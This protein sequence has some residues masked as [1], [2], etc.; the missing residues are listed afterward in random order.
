MNESAIDRRPLASRRL[1]PSRWA[2][3][4]LARSGVTPNQISLAGMFF[5]LASGV[6]LLA[7]SLA[8]APWFRV[9]FVA[10]AVLVQLRLLCNMLDGM[11]A[12]EQGSSS[13]VGELFNEIPDRVSDSATLVGLGFALG[14]NIQL[15]FAAALVAMFTAYIRAMGKASGGPQQFC[16]PMSK[17][18]RMFTVTAVAVYCAC[19][20][21][22]WQPGLTLWS[23]LGLP[24]LALLLICIGAAIA[25]V[26]R[27]ARAAAA[28]RR[29]P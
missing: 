1:A 14:G 27:I 6:A 4:L 20:P 16:G 26:R 8:P 25:S 7:T 2:A 5:G 12:V 24:A 15:G 13:K 3:A 11:V 19:A 21:L 17:P 18:Q 28:L 10:G 9:L 23:P 29:L 22:A